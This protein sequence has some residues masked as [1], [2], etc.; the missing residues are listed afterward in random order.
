[1]KL[2]ITSISLAVGALLL[3][4]VAAKSPNPHRA[5][6]MYDPATEVT[7][8]GTIQEVK[9]MNHHGMMVTGMHLVVKTDDKTDEVILGP[10]NYMTSK[11]FSFTKGDSIEL[12]GSKIKIGETRYIMAREVVKRGKTLNLRDRQGV[13]EW[14]GMMLKGPLQARKP[15]EAN[16]N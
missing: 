5:M 3:S 15:V 9:L 4:L 13:P 2:L 10:A 16:E 12:T 6:R 1:M 8:N 14:R 11:G 7:F